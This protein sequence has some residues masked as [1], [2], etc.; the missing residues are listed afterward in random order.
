MSGP[1]AHRTQKGTGRPSGVP[2]CTRLCN[3]LGVTL[4]AVSSGSELM[5]SG[6]DSSEVRH[7]S[8]EGGCGCVVV[9]FSQCVEK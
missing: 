5:K 3:A 9:I 7:S 1:P 8:N 2:L 6:C 4:S